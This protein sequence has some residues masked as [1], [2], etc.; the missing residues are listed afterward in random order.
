MD[1]DQTKT[2][3][4][5]KSSVSIGRFTYGF[6]SSI[7]KQWNEGAALNIGNFCSI[8]KNVTFMLGGNHRVDWITTYPFG[9]IFQQ[10]LIKDPIIGHP[11][12]NGD[13]NIGNDVWIGSDVAILSGVN[14]G[15]GAV[16]GTR[17][18]VTKDVKP[19]EIVGGNPAKHIKFRFH[20]LI[21]DELLQIK[22]WDLN[23]EIIRKIAVYLC[24]IPDKKNLDLV[25]LIITRNSDS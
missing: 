21:I 13:I 12:T 7:V 19:Y 10:E 8:A 24:Q 1:N 23:I 16:I 4:I 25:K 15:N 18:L 6:E 9:L 3:V 2:G 11:F 17:S 22:W 14:I 5:G 20:P